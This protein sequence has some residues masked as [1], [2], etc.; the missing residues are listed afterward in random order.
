[1]IGASFVGNSA[2][3]P[4]DGKCVPSSMSTQG[5]GGVVCKG[6]IFRRMWFHIKQPSAWI[7]KALCVRLPHQS[8]INNCQDLSPECNCLPYLKKAWKGNVWLAAVGQRYNTQVLLCRRSNHAN[9]FQNVYGGKQKAELLCALLHRWICLSTNSQIQ[10][11][12]TSSC[13]LHIGWSPSYSHTASFSGT[14]STK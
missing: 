5:T 11:N 7:G 9:C 6:H 14:L 13:G 2:L 3:L 4:N 8:T 1:M 12:G 10:K